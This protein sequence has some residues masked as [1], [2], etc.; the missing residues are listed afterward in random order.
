MFMLPDVSPPCMV[1]GGTRLSCAAPGKHVKSKDAGQWESCTGET[2]RAVRA[3][4]GV[5]V[6]CGKRRQ[7]E[8][9][10]NITRKG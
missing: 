2:G 5:T 7:R 8:K 1:T 4:S 10:F 6:M 3:D 9:F